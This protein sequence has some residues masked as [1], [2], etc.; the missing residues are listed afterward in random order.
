MMLSEGTQPFIGR[1]TEKDSLKLGMGSTATDV[2]Y[3]Q[4]ESF[5]KLVSRPWCFIIHER[6][7]LIG[8]ARFNEYGRL[9]W[10]DSVGVAGCEA[11]RVAR[12][13]QANKSLIE[14]K[15]GKIIHWSN[16]TFSERRK[17]TCL[18]TY[19]KSILFIWQ[20]YQSHQPLR[21]DRA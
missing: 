17:G 3:S 13:N 20:L 8:W 4:A 21:M 5:P 7:T 18:V 1:K 2:I 12:I 9:L 14:Q 11:A 15:V 10:R 6:W 19:G 16:G